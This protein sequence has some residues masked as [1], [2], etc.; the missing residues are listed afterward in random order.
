[1]DLSEGSQQMKSHDPVDVIIGDNF[2]GCELFQP[3][4]CDFYFSDV[5]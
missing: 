5:V 1:M 4:Y 2:M 3:R